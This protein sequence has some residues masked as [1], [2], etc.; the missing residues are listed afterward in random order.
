MT[1]ENALASVAV[2]NLDSSI[3]WYEKLFGRP[4]DSRPMW[5]VAEWKFE[6][7][8]WLQVYQ[9]K[10]RFGAGSATLTVSNLE[11]QITQLKKLGL[12]PGQTII[13]AKVKIVMIEDP[14]GNSLAFAEVI[15]PH[16][17]K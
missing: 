17:A 4:A 7:G 5:E 6:R 15:D 13:N 8:G 10:E 3:E 11:Q 9:T 1:I 16:I 14:D 12:E 2:K